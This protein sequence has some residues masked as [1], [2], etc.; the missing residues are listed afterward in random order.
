MVKCCVVCTLSVS[1]AT[2]EIRGIEGSG[3]ISYEQQ[4]GLNGM[5]GLISEMK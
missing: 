5:L 3:T 2:S 4:G 1:G